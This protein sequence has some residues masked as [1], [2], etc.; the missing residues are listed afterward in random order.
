MRVI[1]TISER[2][3]IRRLPFWLLAPLRRIE[4]RI[5]IR[6]KHP[7]RVAQARAVGLDAM[8][9]SLRSYIEEKVGRGSDPTEGIMSAIQIHMKRVFPDTLGMTADNLR[10]VIEKEVA[11]AQ[12]R[13]KEKEGKYDQAGG[14]GCS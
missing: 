1:T 10:R 12:R 9:E 7:G 8:G 6:G 4:I 2:P 14:G 5:A 11:L 3:G 13:L